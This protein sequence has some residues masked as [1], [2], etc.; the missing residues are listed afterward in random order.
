MLARNIK[1]ILILSVTTLCMRE[2]ALSQELLLYGGRNSDQFAGCLNCEKY[3]SRSICNEYGSGSKYDSNSIFNNYGDLGSIYS[4]YSPWNKYSDNG[5]IVVD[6]SGAYYGR[7][8][9]N[10]FS[11]DQIRNNYFTSVY[12]L[13][14]KIRDLDIIRD[15]ICE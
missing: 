13:Y 7:F 9:V 11:T 8:T 12:E 14:E 15:I 10:K 5:P 4:E 3:D 6:S 2:S 1:L